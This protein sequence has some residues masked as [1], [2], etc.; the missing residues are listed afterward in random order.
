MIR[1]AT[2]FAASFA[3]CAVCACAALS[4]WSCDKRAGR[5]YPLPDVSK[6]GSAVA[7]IGP[8]TLTTAELERRIAGQSAFIKNQ[9]VSQEQ[10][11]RFVDNEVRVELLAQEGWK[12]GLYEDPQV[13]Q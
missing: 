1:A 5:P 8:V 11:R 10:R 9:L 13:I 12:L 4:M 6:E 3:S 2:L 7:K